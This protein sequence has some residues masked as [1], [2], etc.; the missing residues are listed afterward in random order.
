MHYSINIVR[1]LRNRIGSYF[2]FYFTC[3]CLFL[4]SP[5]PL[6]VSGIAL[7]AGLGRQVWI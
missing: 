4:G 1:K 2:G 7:L 3:R 5:G 6:S